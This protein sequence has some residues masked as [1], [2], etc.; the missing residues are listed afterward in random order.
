MLCPHPLRLALTFAALTLLACSYVDA[1]EPGLTKSPQPRGDIRI[2]YVA[3]AMS[4][5]RSV[6]PDQ[7]TANHLRGYIDTLASGGVDVFAQDVFQKQGV[8]WFQPEHPD[9][10]HFPGPVDGIPRKD[11]PPIKIAIEQC[12]RR[13]M[14][15]LAVF[16]MADR[17]G[18]GQR[19]LIAKRKDLWNPDFGDGAMDYT[20][21]EI[22]D[23][24]LALVEETLG[25]FDVDGIEFTYTRWMH[26]FPK[27]TARKSHPI[28]T[29]FLRRVRATLD[30]AGRKKGRKLMLGVRVPQTLEECH[31]LGYDVPTWVKGGLIDYVSPCDFFYTD[32]NAQYEEFAALTRKSDCMLYP[33]VHP[34]RCRGDNVGILQPRNYRAAARNMYAAGADGIAQFNYQYH[35]GRRRSGYP[36]SESNYPTSLA[37]LRQLRGTDQFDQFP[38]HY[39]FLPLWGSGSPS[40]FAKNDRIVLNRDQGSSGKYRFRIAEDLSKRGTLAE[41]IVRASHISQEGELAFA[42]NGVPIPSE[43]IKTIFHRQGRPA[44]FGRPLGPHR[45]FMIPLASPPIVFGDNMLEA[46][47]RQA[48]AKNKSAIVI[49]ELEVTVVPGWRR[50]K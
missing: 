8:C 37:W 19:G 50:G 46:T 20:H 28:M 33:T 27:S 15:F 3:D 38:R 31:A 26:C 11:G 12:H 32:F 34:I 40:G 5:T 18:G 9:H 7:P 1:A 41:L 4:D 2:V 30:E 47:V 39:L 29:Q 21:K 10:A 6:L 48:N 25:R 23:W 14:K 13:K 49:D 36:W 44:E 24:V 17:H 42:I 43:N 16:R 45:S 35:F 22:R